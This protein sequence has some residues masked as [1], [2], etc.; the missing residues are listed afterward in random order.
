LCSW[1]RVP[2]PIY[3]PAPYNLPTDGRTPSTA[4]TGNG[5]RE[6]SLSSSVPPHLTTTYARARAWPRRHAPTAT[7]AAWCRRRRRRRRRWTRSTTAPEAAAT[8]PSSTTTIP[9]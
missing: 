9:S 6:E 8:V 7:T 4:P 5:V 1:P 2:T 3:L